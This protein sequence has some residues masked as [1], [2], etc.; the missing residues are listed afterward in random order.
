M[1]LHTFSGLLLAGLLSNSAFALDAA[2]FDQYEYS[3]K[4]QEPQGLAIAPSSLSDTRRG[5]YDFIRLDGAPKEK[6]MTYLDTTDRQFQKA[7][8]IVRVREYVDKPHKSKITV[9]L[10]A[11]NPAGFGN[12]SDYKKAEIDVSGGKQKYSVS[13]DIKYDPDEIDVRRVN[14]EQV[15]A[16]IKKKSPQAWALVKPV[17]EANKAR[18]KQTIVMRSLGWEG[19]LKGIKGSVEMDYAIWS[20]YYKR[21]RTSFSEVSFKGQASEKAFLDEAAS[22]VTRMMQQKGVYTD[23]GDSKTKM[24]FDLSK[25]FK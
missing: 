25:A 23:L 13:Y 2:D 10:R 9:K 7:S 4:T 1:K 11:P 8:I 12:I 22:H 6:L 5:L 14:I 17:Y 19:A 21:P 15:F 20:P 18:L 16:R 3:F 24:T